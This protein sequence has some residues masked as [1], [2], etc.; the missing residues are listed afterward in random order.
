[1]A[2]HALAGPAGLLITWRSVAGPTGLMLGARRLSTIRYD[3]TDAEIEDVIEKSLVSAW[4]CGGTVGAPSTKSRRRRRLPQDKGPKRR[5]DDT[6]SRVLTTR[7][8]AL[9]LYREILRITALFEWRN[10]Q[11][12]PWC[13]PSAAPAP[14]IRPPPHSRLR[15]SHSRWGARCRRD[16]LRESARKEFEAARFEDDPELV[17][18][19]ARAHGAL[20]KQPA[21]HWTH[22]S[23]RHNT[24]APQVTR[25]LV[26]GRDSMHQ[27]AERFAAKHTSVAGGGGPGAPPGAPPFPPRNG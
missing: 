13:A 21:R 18:F 25:L 1:M 22:I 5:E 19:S 16:L 7:R 10:E 27:V 24:A 23:P 8:E 3:A 17:R 11:G 9:S 6:P 20:L 14:C 26:V 2:L 15:R 4:P 12:V